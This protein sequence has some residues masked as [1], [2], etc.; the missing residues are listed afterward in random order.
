[1]AI[2]SRIQAELGGIVSGVSTTSSNKGRS[3]HHASF[4]KRTIAA[5]GFVIKHH[6]GGR[7]GKDRSQSRVASVGHSS[8]STSKS[9]KQSNIRTHLKRTSSSV[10]LLHS[11]RCEC[12]RFQ[13]WY[14]SVE[15]DC[16]CLYPVLEKPCEGVRRDSV[17]ESAH[18]FLYLPLDLSGIH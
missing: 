15:N 3:L 8:A 18:G 9:S 16:P 5:G 4:H 14:R 10:D 13:F 1:M 11:H 12:F 6:G 17:T 2:P 7:R